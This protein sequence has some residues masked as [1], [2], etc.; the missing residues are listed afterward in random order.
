[1]CQISR[2]E[3]G[4]VPSN[5]LKAGDSRNIFLPLHTISAMVIPL[6]VEAH[7]ESLELKVGEGDKLSARVENG[8]VR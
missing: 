3:T 1:M 8:Q 7:A 5:V 6:V 4:V 2:R